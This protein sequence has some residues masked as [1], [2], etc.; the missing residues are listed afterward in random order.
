LR[1]YY[2]IDL[3]NQG[4][5]NRCSSQEEED[6]EHLKTKLEVIFRDWWRQGFPTRSALV[7][8]VMSPAMPSNTSAH[9]F[10]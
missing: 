2:F 7:V 10:M 1:C 6:A 8:A 4:S 9:H 5:K 3:R